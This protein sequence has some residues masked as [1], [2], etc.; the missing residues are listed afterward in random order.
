MEII[1]NPY[2]SLLWTEEQQI[3]YCEFFFSGGKTDRTIY[4]NCPAFGGE[5]GVDIPTKQM[6]CI[7]GLQRLTALRKFLNNEIPIYGHYF[8]DFEDK[9][10]DIRTR[11]SFNINSINTR[12]DLLKWYL[13]MN[14]TGTPHSADELNRVR[15]LL[16]DAEQKN[17]A[18]N[19]KE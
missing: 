10:R 17:Q 9:P 14:S 19:T 16:A 3:S 5:T 12:P 15:K 18:D 4:F 13:S 8:D 6:V 11:L 1:S 2:L 7:D